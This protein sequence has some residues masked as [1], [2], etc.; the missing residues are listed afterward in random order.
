MVDFLGRC[1]G[2][3]HA[4]Q[5]LLILQNPPCFHLEPSS[6]TPASFSLS[7]AGMPPRI[8]AIWL[9]LASFHRLD[10]KALS[11][12]PL[13]PS[14]R[15]IGNEPIGNEPSPH[16]PPFTQ[17]PDF[18]LTQPLKEAAKVSR[19]SCKM[20]ASNIDIRHSVLKCK[21]QEQPLPL[22]RPQAQKLQIWSG[23]HA[24]VGNIWGWKISRYLWPGV[25]LATEGCQSVVKVWVLPVSIWPTSFQHSAWALHSKVC[26]QIM[27]Q[28]TCTLGKVVQPSQSFGACFGPLGSV[29]VLFW[30]GHPVCSRKFRPFAVRL[31]GA[32]PILI[33]SRKE[34]H[35]TILLYY[36]PRAAFGCLCLLTKASFALHSQGPACRS[37][38]AAVQLRVLPVAVQEQHCAI[39]CSGKGRG[40]LQGLSKI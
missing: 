40:C 30:F 33:L 21:A 34:P 20:L 28:F 22:A 17:R 29:S 12:A 39:S 25:T 23:M 19:V 4:I 3:F 18:K 38:A 1:W 8:A 9:P 15:G 14:T 36:L 16:M 2:L 26:M 24:H 35:P 37:V 13:P 7:S 11:H 32:S 5:E 6:Q 10:G 27:N 31:F